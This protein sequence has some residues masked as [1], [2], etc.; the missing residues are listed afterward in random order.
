MA[1]VLVT[2]LVVGAV[3]AALTTA[4][5]GSNNDLVF[6][7]IRGG[8][9]G[10]AIRVRYVDPGAPD[11]AFSIDV[12]GFDIT[13]NLATDGSSV[14]TTTAADVAA[15]LAAHAYANRL[16]TIAYAGSNDG[17]GAVTALSFTALTG[18]AYGVEESA[19]VN[20]DST[21]DHYLTGND[22]TVEL[23]VE[24]TTGSS[25]TVS[26]HYAALA[27]VPSSPEVVTIPNNKVYVIG[28]FAPDL[29]NQNGDGDVYFDPSV[30][31]ASLK[32]KAR[33]VARST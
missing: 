6:T 33:K 30:T 23:E 25:V 11:A 32:F 9:W 10:N 26:V 18:G 16:V 19:A 21:N 28:T 7:A 17:S 24:N 13:V 3:K 22:G 1:R 31:S 4:L 8:S 5:G 27:D 14:I 29:F 2:P 12:D 15:R 20:A